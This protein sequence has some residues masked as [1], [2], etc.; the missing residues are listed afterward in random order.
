[1]ANKWVEFV[2][3]WAKDNNMNYMC[4]MTTPEC[5]SA[6]LKAHPKPQTAT[7]KMKAEQT[8]MAME[9]TPAPA[10]KIDT[11]IE[12]FKSGAKI[13]VELEE[14]I[15]MA[16]KGLL[17]KGE[18]NKLEN[19]VKM[20]NTK[21]RTKR[22]VPKKT[23]VEMAIDRFEAGEDIRSELTEL[24]SQYDDDLL[25][26]DDSEKLEKLVER[27]NAKKRADRKKN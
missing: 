18:K 3:K 11:A 14:L 26:E 21:T 1:M 25:D 4:A 9:D 24:V 8:S 10:S 5:K 15:A 7:T 27:F 13:K 17:N 20:F 16:K 22:L 2:K 12:R 6:Y 19:L 23:K